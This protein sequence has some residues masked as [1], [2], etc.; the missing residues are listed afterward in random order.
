[1]E[2]LTQTLSLDLQALSARYVRMLEESA[3]PDP[4]LERIAVAAVLADLFAL[5]GMPLTPEVEAALARL[6]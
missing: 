6:Q 2:T 5:A 4:L 1:M 3:I